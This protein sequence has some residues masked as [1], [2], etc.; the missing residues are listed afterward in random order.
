MQKTCD[1]LEFR[2]S[3]DD[4][5]GLFKL[6]A[7]VTVQHVLEAATAGTTSAYIELLQHKSGDTARLAVEVLPAF[8]ALLGATAASTPSVL[9]HHARLCTSICW[10]GPQGVYPLLLAYYACCD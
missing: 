8:K 1:Y 5:L 4:F 10:R 6:R 2:H 3:A 9:G 7:G